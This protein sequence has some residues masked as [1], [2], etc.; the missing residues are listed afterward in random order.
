MI[1]DYSCRDEESQGNSEEI[2]D[3]LGVVDDEAN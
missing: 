3:N 1:S 2:S